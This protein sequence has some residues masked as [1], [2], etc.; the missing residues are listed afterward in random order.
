MSGSPRKALSTTFAPEPE[1]TFTEELTT[2]SQIVQ[3]DA[4]GFDC[5]REEDIDVAFH[6]SGKG[7]RM[8]R[9]CLPEPCDAALTQPD[10]GALIGRPPTNAEWDDYYARYADT[11]RREVTAFNDTDPLDPAGADVPGDPVV[12]F[13]T[14][15]VSTYEPN[16][17][18]RQ[19]LITRTSSTS[20]SRFSPPSSTLTSGSPV[21]SNLVVTTTDGGDGDDGNGNDPN[22]A[23]DIRV[24]SSGGDDQL[25]MT[26]L[27]SAAWLMIA[28]ILGAVGFGRWTSR[29]A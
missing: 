23:P 3:V 10:L 18:I 27:P 25:L 12:D 22:P 7:T 11:C 26:P 9:T 15:L 2:I 20:Q 5:I 16:A 6:L 14:P 21:L 28:A 1:G 8:P 29:R 4:L 24:V 19:A 17:P 13:W